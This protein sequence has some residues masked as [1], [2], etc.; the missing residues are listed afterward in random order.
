LR[1]TSASRSSDGA[2]FGVS[3][4]SWI[5]VRSS[6]W[7]GP[8]D[9]PSRSCASAIWMEFNRVVPSSSRLSISAWVPSRSC[10]SAAA[11]ASNSTATRVTGTAARRA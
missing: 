1:I 4:V 3:A 10:G 2:R 5:A 11:P 9:A 6:D 8:M 7:L